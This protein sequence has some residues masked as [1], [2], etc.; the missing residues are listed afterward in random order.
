MNHQTLSSRQRLRSSQARQ[1]TGSNST[2]IAFTPRGVVTLTGVAAIVLAIVAGDRL[3]IAAE[4][5]TDT[6]Q[7]ESLGPAEAA[8]LVASCPGVRLCLTP[9]NHPGTSFEPGLALNG[10][11]TLDPATARVLAGCNRFP[12]ITLDGLSTLD[13]DTARA[14]AAGSAGLSL[15]G[16]TRIDLPVA[17]ALARLA[18]SALVVNGPVDAEVARTLATFRGS[19]HPASVLGIT[20]LETLAPDAA[21]ALAGFKGSTL[22]IGGL[23]TLDAGVARTLAAV[24]RDCLALD[25]LTTLEVDAAA[26]LAEFPGKTLILG[27]LESLDAEAARAL[28]RFGGQTLGVG[29]LA[30]L[31]AEAARALGEFR[32]RWC[33]VGITAAAD[34]PEIFAALG[35]R[36]YCPTTT[37]GGRTP[38]TLAIARAIADRPR[39]V[40]GLLP[41]LTAFTDPDSVAIAAALA[42]RQGSLALPNLQ[43]VSPKTMAALLA[44]EDVE[45]PLIETLE[46]IA[47]PDGGET[48]D[49]TIPE[50]VL[51]RQELQRRR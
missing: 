33:F 23:R 13:S 7:I 16:L 15:R 24:N 47:E 39:Q 5:P 8:D 51:K 14:L 35:D 29:D 30:V 28:A 44:K 42:R 1:S 21:T 6:N 50:A 31:D 20:G 17:S 43:R 25:G 18:G 36:I 46:L 3:V 9:A 40:D 10:L 12:M 34:V 41:A 22:L 37:V 27:G 2:S 4:L 48:D 19:G 49:L 26:A 11:Q 38:L 45:I 32:G